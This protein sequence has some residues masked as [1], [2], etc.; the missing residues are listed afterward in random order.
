[1]PSMPIRG[2][3]PALLE[4]FTNAVSVLESFD[5]DGFAE[6]SLDLIGTRNGRAITCMRIED[7][8]LTIALPKLE[9][10]EPHYL[11]HEIDENRD[12]LLA[13]DLCYVMQLW[14]WSLIETA[15]YFQCSEERLSGLLGAQGETTLRAQGSTREKIHRLLIVENA[16][17]LKGVAD[18]YAADWI[19][20]P[21]SGFQGRSV[22][23]ILIGG[24]SHSFARLAIWALQP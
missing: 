4:L 13:A 6:V 16:R 22:K 9:T 8:E 14:R 20:Q 12:A 10:E 3:L 24:D 18:E 1:M 2:N 7:H 11:H 21:R 19:E 15:A 5:I 17:Q 23:E